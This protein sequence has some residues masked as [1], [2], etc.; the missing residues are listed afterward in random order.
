MDGVGLARHALSKSVVASVRGVDA[1]VSQSLRMFT[2]AM[3]IPS[4][5]LIRASRGPRSAKWDS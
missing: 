4:S 2:T 1:R 3:T 5:G